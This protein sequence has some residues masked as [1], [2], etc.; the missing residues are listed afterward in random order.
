MAF[1]KALLKDTKIPLD[2]KLHYQKGRSPLISLELLKRRWGSIPER[3][4]TV[5]SKLFLLHPINNSRIIRRPSNSETPTSELNK[6]AAARALTTTRRAVKR[7]LRSQ[8]IKKIKCKFK[9]HCISIKILKK[10][11]LVSFFK[12]II[13]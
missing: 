7:K 4:A 6:K 3:N 5:S 2:P 10:M 13:A 9:T 11:E 1:K 12:K 8:N